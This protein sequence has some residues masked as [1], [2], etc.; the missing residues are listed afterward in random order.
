VF[1]PATST[2]K[3]IGQSISDFRVLALDANTVVWATGGEQRE[4]GMDTRAARCHARQR[5]SSRADAKR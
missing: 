4:Q 3:P 5:S 2:L 1:H